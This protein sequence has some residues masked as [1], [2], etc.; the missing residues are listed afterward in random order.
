ME[1]NVMS[2]ISQVKM[3]VDWTERKLA[4]S[5]DVEAIMKLVTDK[6]EQRA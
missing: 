3:A 2:M 1:A 5:V 6:S 4:R